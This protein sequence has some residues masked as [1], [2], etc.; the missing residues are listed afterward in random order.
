MRP[1]TINAKRL[2]LS[3]YPLGMRLL[4]PTSTRGAVA[5]IA[6]DIQQASIDALHRGLQILA[7]MDEDFA[8]EQNGMGF[9]RFDVRIG[10]DLA[11][12]AFLTPKQEVLAA[13]L[14]RKYRRQLPADI[15]DIS[16]ET[17]KPTSAVPAE[18]AR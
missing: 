16:A 10:H 13:K 11:T 12:R 15:V 6:E 4:P 8:R 17:L 18:H 2:P 5:K 3:H 14:C 1:W 9:G 7:G